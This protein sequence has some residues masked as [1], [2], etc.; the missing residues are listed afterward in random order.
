MEILMKGFSVGNFKSFNDL[1]S[2]SFAT[3]KITKHPTHIYKTKKGKYLK[4]AIVFGANASGKSNLIKAISFSRDIILKG[5][6][7]VNI[8][9]NHFRI[10]E[11]SYNE[12]AIFQYD[13]IM[14]NQEY[15][16]GFTLSYARGVIENEWL[17]RVNESN[18]FRIFERSLNDQSLS[19]VETDYN[20][21]KEYEKFF[22]YLDDFS[23][24]I[25]KPL[26]EKTI[27]ADI[28]TRSKPTEEPFKYIKNLYDYISDMIIIFPDTKYNFINDVGMLSE[29]KDFFENILKYFD[30]GIESLTSQKEEMNLNKLFY[31]MNL[32]IGKD[33]KAE[34]S[35]L[36]SKHPIRYR[37]GDQIYT[38]RKKK[39]GRLVCNKLLMNHGNDEAL[40]E[41]ADE[42]DGTKRLFDLI[43]LLKDNGNPRIIIIDEIDRSLHTNL[44][45]QFIQLFFEMH[46]NNCVQLLATAQDSNILDLKLLRQDEIWFVERQVDHSSTIYS[47][48]E[49]K[50]RSDKDVQKDYLLGRYG[51]VPFFINSLQA[52]IE[53]VNEEKD[54]V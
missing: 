50:E 4:S 29:K 51:A 36:S 7:N 14:D 28:A 40:F 21:K 16:Y 52:E 49:F 1:Q 23:S 12:P 43:P 41:L 18:E 34:I 19:E 54:K 5:L 22:S 45:K 48:N 24:D 20:H 30:T 47:L 39:N 11:K 53:K 33:Q 46:A 10:N 8:S 2:I 44:I 26:M 27:L 3:S 15:L 13:F 25:A 35:R 6:N 17:I 42:S 37:L 38:I 9:G 32:E 31:L